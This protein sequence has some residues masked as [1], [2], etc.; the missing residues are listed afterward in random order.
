MRQVKQGYDDSDT[1]DKVANVSECFQHFRLM[2][3]ARLSG[4]LQHT[5]P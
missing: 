3:N 5:F 4:A 2:P 1:A